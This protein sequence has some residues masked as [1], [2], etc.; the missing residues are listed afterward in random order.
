[1]PTNQ[2][3]HTRIQRISVFFKSGGASSTANRLTLFLFLFSPMIYQTVRCPEKSLPLFS[4]GA[5]RLS[6]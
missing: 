5:D 2:R 4:K 1:M 6:Q 3:D